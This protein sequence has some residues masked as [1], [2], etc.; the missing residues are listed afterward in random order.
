MA[1]GIKVIG[2]RFYGPRDGLR[3]FKGKNDC[4]EH[5]AHIAG[6]VGDIQ[7]EVL[8]CGH[9]AGLVLYEHQTRV[10]GGAVTPVNQGNGIGSADGRGPMGE[11][12]PFLSLKMVDGNK[13]GTQAGACVLT[14]PIEE[15]AR[16][17]LA[18]PRA[19]EVAVLTILAPRV[20]GIYQV[21][22][23]EVR[24]HV[25]YPFAEL[26]AGGLDAAFGRAHGR[27]R[28]RTGTVLPTTWAGW[29]GSTAAC[30]RSVQLSFRHPP[31]A[32]PG[33]W[34]VGTLAEVRALALS[35][36]SRK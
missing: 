4:N 17:F 27:G 8:G 21:D 32:V 19:G 3:R 15:T 7:A 6:A 35:L 25:A 36:A 20:G 26:A 10:W 30:G 28:P 24:Y 18:H 9:L 11:D 34:E 1:I 14:T 2:Q 16:A 22:P 5:P 29:I 13:T 23:S 33:A 12:L 31:P